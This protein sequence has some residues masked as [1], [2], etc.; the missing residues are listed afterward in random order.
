MIGGPVGGMLGAL[1]GGLISKASTSSEE[2]SQPNVEKAQAAETQE[3]K[4]KIV[5]ASLNPEEQKTIKEAAKKTEEN[6]KQDAVKVNEPKI[7]QRVI[8][9]G[10]VVS[11]TGDYAAEEKQKAADAA[12]AKPEMSDEDKKALAGEEISKPAERVAA[13]P[14]NAKL[15]PAERVAAAPANAKLQPAAATPIPSEPSTAPQAETISQAAVVKDTSEQ[16]P[17]REAP[18]EKNEG[19]STTN[20][21]NNIQQTAA[22][23][24]NPSL[25]WAE[26]VMGYY[27][28]K[29]QVKMGS[30]HYSMA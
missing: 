20:I 28:L 1:A 16:Q 13:A 10:K 24:S 14:A 5:K 29:D 26:K 2:K 8:V 15:Q 23:D 30:A 6:K 25:S 19:G 17:V 4:P 12:K 7:S 9:N 18:T 11:A 27:E 21:N 3:Q 22:N